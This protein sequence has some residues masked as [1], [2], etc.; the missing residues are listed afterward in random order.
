[1]Q[2]GAR[3]TGKWGSK[4]G[5]PTAV[6]GDRGGSYDPGLAACQAGGRGFEPRHSRHAPRPM[7]QALAAIPGAVWPD[8][9][10]AP[11][12]PGSATCCKEMQGSGR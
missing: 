7:N 3:S 8:G 4:G 1:V 10:P 11:A 12:D 5:S 2:V 9:A 6:T